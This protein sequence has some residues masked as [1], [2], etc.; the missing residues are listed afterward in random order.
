MSFSTILLVDDEPAHMTLIERNLRRIGYDQ[1]IIKLNDGA[2]VM[3][4]LH[5]HASGLLEAP[6]I[7]LDVNMPTKNGLDVLKDIKNNRSTQHIPVVML[8]TADNP[9]EVARCYRLGCNAYVKKPVF[10]N[11]FKD[12]VKK[13][14]LF[15]S[16]VTSPRIH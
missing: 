13:L 15:L 5:M 16:V 11:D 4:W 1:D 10:H 9:D 12:V 7:F 2:Q 8:T 14:G 6:F 3:E